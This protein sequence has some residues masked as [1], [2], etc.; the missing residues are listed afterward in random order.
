MSKSDFNKILDALNELKNS[1]NFI[2]FNGDKQKLFTSIAR[3]ETK[4]DEISL[5]QYGK[6]ISK[7]KDKI[8]TNTVGIEKSKWAFFVA[9]FSVLASLSSVVGVVI[10]F[11]KLTEGTQ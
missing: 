8:N 5:Q 9:V 1:D 2:I 4:L 10:L 11:V 6:Q 3:I 7:L